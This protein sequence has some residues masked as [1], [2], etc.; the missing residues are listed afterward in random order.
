MLTLPKNGGHGSVLWFTD[1]KETMQV[2]APV[3]FSRENENQ[4]THKVDQVL[5]TDSQVSIL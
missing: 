2:G 5:T 4:V 1:V 3:A